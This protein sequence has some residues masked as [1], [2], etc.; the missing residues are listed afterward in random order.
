M[1]TT[2]RQITFSA[3]SYLLSYPDEEWRAELP[4]WKAL[5]LEIGNQQIREKSRT[6]SMR[7]PAFLKKR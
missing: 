5:I 2:D 3:L 1:N 7:Q 6:F 4:D